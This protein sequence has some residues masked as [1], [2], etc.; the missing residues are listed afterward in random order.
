[1]RYAGSTYD[2]TSHY[3]A[4]RVL[5]F[6]DE[7][8]LSPERLRE[9]YLHQ[10]TLLAERFDELGLPDVTRDRETALSAFGG[11]IAF[12]SARAEELSRL[13][14]DEGVVTDSRGSRLRF[15]PAPYH[16]DEQLEAAIEIL[17]RVAR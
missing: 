15:G 5:D 4:A 1:M 8:G 10:T 11:F 13:L 12:E 17:G 16:S 7:Q 14:L 2:P 3:R 6:F 9:R